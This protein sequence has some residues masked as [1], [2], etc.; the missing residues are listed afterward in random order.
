M[1]IK[2][3]PIDVLTSICVRLLADDKCEYC[4]KYVG[5]KRLQCSHFFGR[6][7]KSIRYDL[8][9]CSALCMSCHM[10]LGENPYLH[11]EWFKKRLG[12][13]KFEELSIRA[14]KIVRLTKEDKEKIKE[15]LKEKIK[16][17]EEQ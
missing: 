13:G 4:G 16:L 17:L 7:R 3:D 2:I 1:K 14:I 9:N 15:D 5:F 8:D 11:T 10:F 6:R 12:S